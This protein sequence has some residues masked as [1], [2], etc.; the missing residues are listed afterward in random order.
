V[1]RCFFEYC[2]L[3]YTGG[4]LSIDLPPAARGPPKG[5]VLYVAFSPRWQQDGLAIAGLWQGVWVTHD[6]GASW[7]QLSGQ[8]K[9][10]PG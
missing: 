10:Q 1:R 8:E 2:E 4:K 5:A 3:S 9:G 7:R 6:R